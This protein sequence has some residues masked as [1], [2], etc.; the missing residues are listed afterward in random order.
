[1]DAIDQEL[2]SRWAAAYDEDG[3]DRSLI[4]QALAQTPTE[5]LATLEEYLETIA[6][7]RR[8]EP[9]PSE[10]PGDASTQSHSSSSRPA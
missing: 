6:R 3:V 2:D 5:R 10:A 7:A 8:L 4:R 1:M 9:E